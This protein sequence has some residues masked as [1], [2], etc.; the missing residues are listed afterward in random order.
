MGPSIYVHEM[1]MK[2]STSGQNAVTKHKVCLHTDVDF[3][4][5]RLRTV[6]SPLSRETVLGFWIFSSSVRNINTSTSGLSQP[7]LRSHNSYPD[8]RLHPLYDRRNKRKDLMFERSFRLMPFLHFRLLEVYTRTR[9][10]VL[11]PIPRLTSNSSLV[12]SV[13]RS[14]EVDLVRC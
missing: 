2:T 4:A 10:G 7:L 14:H 6:S 13:N 9:V 3:L 11:Y 8:V 5:S 1:S 12:A